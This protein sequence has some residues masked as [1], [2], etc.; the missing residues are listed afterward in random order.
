LRTIGYIEITCL[1]LISLAIF[2]SCFSHNRISLLNSREIK[3]WVCVYTQ[4]VSARDVASFDVAVLDADAHPDL[5]PSKQA[6]TLT[7]GY[8]SLGEIASYRW[9]WNEVSNE[10]WL[11]DKNPNWDSFMIDVREEAW[12]DFLLER[13]APRILQKGF[14]GLF[15]DTI[16]T[17]EYLE[18][19]HPTKKGPG[20]EKA[21]VKLIRKLRKRFPNTPI[22]ANRGFSLLPEMA[23]EIDGILAESIFTEIDF[24]NNTTFIRTEASFEERLELLKNVQEKHKLVVFTLDYFHNKDDARIGKIIELSRLHGFVPFISRKELDTIYFHTINGRSG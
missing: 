7:L 11:L 20:A 1:C 14:D 5:R 21:M 22:V 3:N 23:S 16:D 13:I 6:N 15:L 19:D 2:W 12:H 8:I 17:A 24:G 9:F 4:E 10:P 18:K